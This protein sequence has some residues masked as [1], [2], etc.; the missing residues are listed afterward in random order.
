M[1]DGDPRGEPRI[2]AIRGGLVGHDHD[3]A[4]PLG[5]QLPRELRDGQLARERLPACRGRHVVVEDLV[6]HG[7]AGRHRGA[8]RQHARVVVGA[9][10]QVG[11]DMRGVGEGGLADPRHPLRA[12]MGEDLGA[13]EDVG[14]HEVAA[15]AGHAVAAFRHPGRG[16][17]GAAGAEVGHAPGV[18]QVPLQLLGQGGPGHGPLLLLEDAEARPQPLVA[19]EARDASGDHPRDQ[20][21]G[22]LPRR[23]QEPLLP[24]G[25]APGRVV[26]LADDPGPP[27]L[28]PVVELGLDLGLEKWAL[29]LHDQDLLQP[30]GEPAHPLRLERPG[31]P[32]LVEADADLRGAP[33]VDAEVVQRLAHIKVGLASRDDAEPRPRAVEHRL[34]EPV[35]AGI[36]LGRPEPVLVD[37]A[38]HLERL[39]RQ[40]DIE[41]VR[42]EHEVLRQA[43]G[44][45]VRVHVHRGRALDGLV[46]GLEPDPA[47]GVAGHGPAVDAQV[48][49]VLHPRGAQ[50]RDHGRGQHGLALGRD[51][52]GARHVVVPGHQQHAAVAGAPGGVAVVE[53]V[54]A[55][56]DAGP[57]AVP[58]GEDA[59]VAGALEQ[60]DL[61]ASP[62][63]GEPQLLVEPRLEADVVLDEEGL[64]PP[65]VLVHA[66]QRRALE[67]GDEAGGVQP[68]SRVPLPLHDGEPDE[69]L[70]AGEEDPPGLEGVLVVQGH[71]GQRHDAA[72]L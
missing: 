36:G 45:P 54:P 63:R 20:L 22:E 43:H 53:D 14:R 42:R 58:Q 19:E 3:A 55:A 26:E 71:C 9:I 32:D 8:D 38:L 24:A 16:V 49:V 48:E 4:H 1:A 5:G 6:R 21:G 64:G 7:D 23:G 18:A 12:H 70:D 56:A 72:L 47:P 67:A 17:V 30:L 10:P 59:V 33:R 52:G 2:A 31:H 25:R 62:H 34:V 37:P 66:V 11:E 29:L 40:P 46:D 35:C 39:V 60:R 44:D 61:L 27:R 13:R 57:L 28:G 15:H 68:R 50:H 41:P 65:E 69:G 51:G